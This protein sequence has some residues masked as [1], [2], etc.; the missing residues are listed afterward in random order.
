MQTI[1]A[2]CAS[3]DGAPREALLACR[4][5]VCE[6]I[7]MAIASIQWV[8][9]S[10]RLDG[11]PVGEELEILVQN[12]RGILAEE[13]SM[14]SFVLHVA[15]VKMM[16]RLALYDERADYQAGGCTAQHAY[17]PRPCCLAPA[18]VM[19][20]IRSITQ[21]IGSGVDEYTLDEP[22]QKERVEDGYLLLDQSYPGSD[23]MAPSRSLPGV[24]VDEDKILRSLPSD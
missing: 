3:L 6:R 20:P 18:A 19:A 23:H 8:V 22:L 11:N 1:S 10:D 24:V 4:E 7:E 13:V 9:R 14:V 2:D 17:C 12:V 5:V 16:D 15:Q 21:R